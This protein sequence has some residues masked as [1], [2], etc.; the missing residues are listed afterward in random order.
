MDLSK[1][2]LELEIVKCEAAITGFLEGVEIHKILL[3]GLKETL[4]KQTFK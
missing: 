3:E 2:I 4:K 1:N